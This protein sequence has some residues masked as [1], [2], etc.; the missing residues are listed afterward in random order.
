MRKTITI[1][2]ATFLLLLITP[3]A[4]AQ[5]RADSACV[6][7]YYAK[8]YAGKSILLNYVSPR[9]STYS[10]W[11]PTVINYISLTNY[12][13]VIQEFVPK[14]LEITEKEFRDKMLKSLQDSL[15]ILIH[16]TKEVCET[17]DIFKTK[18][19][20]LNLDPNCQAIRVISVIDGV[21]RD[22]W[23]Y[24]D[25]K[26][27]DIISH[28]DENLEQV[29]QELETLEKDMCSLSRKIDNELLR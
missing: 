7:N 15:I 4:E 13:N 14:A 10:L 24:F 29:R 17:V 2:A 9:D 21:K 5:T 26:S 11:R 22:E 6:I 8:I 1:I 18:R 12:F 23:L 27:Q 19:E 3:C 25:A 20:L 28:S 16:R